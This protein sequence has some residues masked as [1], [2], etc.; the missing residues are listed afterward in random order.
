MIFSVSIDFLLD[1][2]SNTLSAIQSVEPVSEQD[3]KETTEK[4]DTQHDQKPHLLV[5][6]LKLRKVYK[7]LKSKYFWTIE[8]ISRGLSSGRQNRPWLS[9]KITDTKWASGRD[10]NKVY[11]YRKDL[12]HYKKWQSPESSSDIVMTQRGVNNKYNQIKSKIEFALKSVL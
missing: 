8:N 5:K 11:E 7:D 10:F 6:K 1:Q 9:P 3:E 12:N 2:D 4:S